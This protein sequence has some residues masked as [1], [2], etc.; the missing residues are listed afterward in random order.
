MKFYLLLITFIFSFSIHAQVD[1]YL[2]K[3]EVIDISENKWKLSSNNDE[4]MILFFQNTNFDDSLAYSNF[5]TVKNNTS[6]ADTVLVN[7][8]INSTLVLLELD[9]DTEVS[10]LKQLV[11]NNITELKKAYQMH[12]LNKISHYLDDN[13]IIGIIDFDAKN[14]SY[15]PKFKLNGVH[16][17]DYY[18][19]NVCL[20]PI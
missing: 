9:S 19:Y 16:I 5:K 6:F 8:I 7:P 4:L 11:L 13:D 18:E 10:K 15:S 1:K 17:G 20:K 3:F 2:L 14:Y 12:D